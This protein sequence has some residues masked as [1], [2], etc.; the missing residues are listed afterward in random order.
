MATY[1]TGGGAVLY[2]GDQINRLSGYNQEGVFGWPGV[3][4]YE[5][6]G[7][8]PITSTTLTK[9][10]TN[11][12]VPSPDRRV[13]DRVRD[14]LTS[15]VVPASSAQPSFIYGASIAIAQDIP[16]GSGY[17]TGAL[18]GFPG[19][20]VTADLVATTS[21]LLLFGPD[22]A[23]VPAGVSTA[24]K[25][26][27]IGNAV[28]YL[29]AAGSALT[30]GTSALSNGNAAAGSLPFANSVTS[31]AIVAADFYSSMFYKVT[32]ATT[33]GIYSVLTAAATTANGSGV[34]ISAAD[35]ANGK[36]GYI[37]CR[38]NYLRAASAAG[39]REIQGFIDFPSQIG[40]GDGPG[41]NG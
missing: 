24:N 34:A 18:P 22:N 19:V 12:T 21:D 33:F 37:V 36:T 28:A 23:G 30:Q 2:P 6:V 40:G 35:V 7:Y 39:W 10:F 29:T 32:S 17:G 27:G 14:N 26:L 11:I 25:A 8:V 31:A 20:P 16:S 13:D 15:L 9:T 38:I 41:V 4:A 3:E 1:K 5:I